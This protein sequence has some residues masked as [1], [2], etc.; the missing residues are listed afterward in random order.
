MKNDLTPF[1][2]DLLKAVNLINST[3]YNHKNFMEWNT[4]ERQI[5]KKDGEII[6]KALGCFVAIKP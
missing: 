1:E 4:N 3:K 5:S 6:Y 2:K